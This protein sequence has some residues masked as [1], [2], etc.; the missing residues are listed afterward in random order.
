[1][2]MKTQAAILRKPGDWWEMAELDLDPPGA[3]EVL[4]RFMAAG[5]CH[6][7][8]HI[9][10]GFQARL[11]MVG[12]HEGAGIIEAVG[13]G[14]TRVAEGDRIACSFIPVC[15]TCRWCSTGHQ[16][17]CDAGL[18]AS[19]GCLPDGTFRFHCDGE[20]LGGM[21][22][23]GTFSRYAVL[24]E[25]SCVKIEDD[26]PFEIA[27]LVSCGVTTGWCS[28][29]YAAGVRAGDTVVVFGIGGVGINAVQGAR[30]AG[31]KNLIAIDPVELKLQMA[32][33]LGATHVT[34]DPD[35]ARRLVVE[36]T[37]GQLADHAIL[38]VGEMNAEVVQQA[39]DLVGK[40]GQVTM[41]G[42]GDYEMRLPGNILIGYQRRLQGAL[43]G[44]AN[45]LHDIP[46]I[47]GLYR[48]GDIKLD[49]LVSRRYRLDQVNDGYR[50]M[51]DG[52][53]IRGVIIHEH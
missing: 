8:E 51:L 43:F 1:M 30:F 29:V 34:T 21:C 13:P 14:V 11:P 4:V 10:A 49:E 20:D 2:T 38:T 3:G 22:V 19:T 37:R 16:N 39:V 36:L 5:L 45:P 47:L 26:V 35:E 48:S 40:T 24:S 33:T 23:L 17:L 28:A 6:S 42:V 53:N 50:D 25:W 44:G 7:D 46:K 15:G 32:R 12:G 52:K 31:A 9:R 41:T 18:N 27:A